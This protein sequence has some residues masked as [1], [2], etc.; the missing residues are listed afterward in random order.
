MG[1]EML[2]PD[3]NLSHA[4]FSVHEGKIVFALA[5]IKGCGG[6]AGQAIATARKSGGPFQSL[7]DFCE[8]C[9]P[10]VVN[11]TAIESL[12]KAGAF[13]KMHPNRA[14]LWE[15]LDRAV[16]AG[17]AKLAD[18]RAG[19][20]GLFD[21]D[22]A[23]ETA[24]TAGQSLVQVP[25]WPDRERMANEK[26]VLGFYL[27]SH[28]L[29]EHHDLLSTHCSHTTVS[30]AE[31]AKGT[32]I[33]LGG[34]LSSLKFSHTKTVRQGSTNTKY[35]M[36]DLEDLDGIVRCIVWPE[37]FAK[38]GS[39]VQA[40]AILAV[41]GSVDRRPG[42]EEA[43]LIVNELFP[44]DDLRRRG[45]KGVLI[46][47]VEV[48]HGLAALETLREIVAEYPG[49]LELQ[50]LLSLADGQRLFLNSNSLRI[51]LNAEFRER[52]DRLLGPGN[53]RAVTAPPAA[54]PPRTGSNGNNARR[55]AMRV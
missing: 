4:D 17:A 30:M 33:T 12:V 3:V 51:D 1:V 45:T 5:A 8:R 20:R 13:D 29:D 52:I 39:L 35:V 11:R 10:A 37:E 42:S 43:N 6:T 46:R 38:F 44:L 19:Q 41:R 47:I 14:S 26:E 32:E 49:Q 16:Q 9:D 2:P 18:L 25:E 50:L 28:P 36:F 22:S 24:S 54:I 34:M 31:L 7:F 53:V 55:S 23:A 40:D 21:D 15:S 27:N 48:T